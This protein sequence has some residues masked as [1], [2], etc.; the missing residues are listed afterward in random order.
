MAPSGSPERGRMWGDA[1]ISLSFYRTEMQNPA[2]QYSFRYAGG[3]ASSRGKQHLSGLCV[4]GLGGICLAVKVAQ[5]AHLATRLDVRIPLLAV[6]VPADALVGRG[7]GLV[8]GD[9]AAAAAVA[10]AY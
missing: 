8:G 3:Q 9:R 4:I 7:L 2:V 10:P 5:A 1:G 6:L